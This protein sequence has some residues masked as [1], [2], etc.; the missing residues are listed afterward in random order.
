MRRRGRR[1]RRRRRRRRKKSRKRGKNHNYHYYSNY[2][3]KIFDNFIHLL[4]LK[5]LPSLY[6]IP[7]K[8]I[9]IYK[10]NLKNNY[11]LYHVGT[12]T[13]LKNKFTIQSYT[14][15]ITTI[16]ITYYILRICILQ[17]IMVST[18]KTKLQ[19]HTSSKQA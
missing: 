7:H 17:Y 8:Y 11:P 3:T 5:F 16:N 4:W 18:I 14:I 2:I 1:R 6:N 12:K 19:K 9:M 10:R 13:L 15:H